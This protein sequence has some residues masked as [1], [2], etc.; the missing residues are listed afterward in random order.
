MSVH[1]ILSYKF[2]NLGPNEELGR[3]EELGPIEEFSE[4]SI[5][6]KSMVFETCINLKILKILVMSF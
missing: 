4:M 2:D 1:T 6:A 5:D 3:A